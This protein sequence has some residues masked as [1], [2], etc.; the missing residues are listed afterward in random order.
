MSEISNVFL[1]ALALLV[2]GASDQLLVI[3][4][5]FALFDAFCVRLA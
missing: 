4:R 2:E 1:E 3:L 5:R